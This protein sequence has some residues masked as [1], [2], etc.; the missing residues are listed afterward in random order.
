MIA[1][2]TSQRVFGAPAEIYPSLQRIG[3]HS[4]FSRPSRD[5]QRLA[6]ICEQVIPARVAT[7]FQGSRPSAILGRI[8]AVVI[9]SLEAR[10]FRAFTNISQEVFK[11]VPA[12]ADGDA[13]PPIAREGVISGLLAAANHVLPLVVD[14]RLAHSVGPVAN[15]PKRLA[16]AAA[17]FGVP[18]PKSRTQNDGLLAAVAQAM[19]RRMLPVSSLD[20]VWRSGSDSQATKACT[21]E[22]RGKSS[23]RHGLS[24][25]HTAAHVRGYV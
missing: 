25:N 9:N 15:A 24:I 22:I 1:Q 10:A 21:D 7:L 18:A 13:S 3:S 19:P 6:L 20:D 5:R 16:V 11:D 12:L 2:W 14:Q 17:A 4:L 8:G 23:F